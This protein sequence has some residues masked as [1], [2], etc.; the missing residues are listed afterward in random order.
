MA[1]DHDRPAS[2]PD[3]NGKILILRA[4]ERRDR[5]MRFLRR[6][7]RTQRV[8]P[9]GDRRAEKRHHLVPHVAMD[10]TAMCFDG[11][12]DPF[13][14]AP[15]GIVKVFGVQALQ[16]ARIAGDI[17]EH[18]GDVAALAGNRPGGGD[19]GFRMCPVV[20]VI[21]TDI[22]GRRPGAPLG[23]PFDGPLG[24]HRGFVGQQFRPAPAAELVVRIVTEITRRTDTLQRCA[25]F[26]AEAT[27]GAIVE[28]AV[29]TFQAEILPGA[30]G[31]TGVGSHI[32]SFI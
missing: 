22:H 26:G 9:M 13:E 18:D 16:H 30:L 8:V 32:Y 5:L 4:G 17:S 10:G 31:R 7:N 29:R 20:F 28:C 14:K 11:P 19:I 27:T 23:G 3:M 2:D 12:V 6:Q 15:Y 1:G 24:G 25:A 21:R